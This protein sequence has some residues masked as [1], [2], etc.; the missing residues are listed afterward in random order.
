MR[1]IVANTRIKNALRLH[2][3]GYRINQ[4]PD[5]PRETE[6]DEDQAVV[7]RRS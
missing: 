2:L 6:Q 7:Q 3:L 5:T 4:V 1:H